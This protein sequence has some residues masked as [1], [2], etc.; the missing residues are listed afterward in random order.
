[1]QYS[2][3]ATFHRVFLV[4]DILQVFCHRNIALVWLINATE[5]LYSNTSHMD[6]TMHHRGVH[7]GPYNCFLVMYGN[8]SRTIS[9]ATYQRMNNLNLRER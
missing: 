1:M 3:P 6:Y 8:N 4:E 2:L 5:N 9:S 7:F